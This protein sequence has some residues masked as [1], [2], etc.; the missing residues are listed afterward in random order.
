MV[1]FFL[2]ERQVI[3]TAF[4]ACPSPCCRGFTFPFRR[5]LLRASITFRS[6]PTSPTCRFRS[7]PSTPIPT[8]HNP[9][10]PG[11]ERFSVV[12]RWRC[13]QKTVW[14]FL[15]E[16]I[17]A[18]CRL[19]HCLPPPEFLVRYHN[20][21]RSKPFQLRKRQLAAVHMHGAEFRAAPQ[22]RDRL[23]GIQQTRWI[24]SGFHCMKLR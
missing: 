14:C 21:V 17:M 1:V 24:K 7:V 23:A 9:R 8:V 6:A 5:F 13:G 3:P 2:G 22:G 15:L 20:P 4:S 10:C 11:G 19:P 16:Y 12:C 18:V